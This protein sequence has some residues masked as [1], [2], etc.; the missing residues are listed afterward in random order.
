MIFGSI[1]YLNLL[2]FKIFLKKYIK[3]SSLKLSLNKKK[4]VPSKINSDLEKRRVDAG[5]ISSVKSSKFR[6]NNIGIVAKKEV[7]S[8]FVIDG[9]NKKDKESATSNIL[10]DIL[11]LNGEVIIG[12]K[13]LKYYLEGGK[14]KDLAKEWHK[15]TNLPFVFARFCYNKN[16]KYFNKLSR[17]FEKENI[18]IPQYL[19]KKEAEK[20]GITT[21]QL[22]WYLSFI[23]YKIDK[24]ALRGLNLFL[25]KS[26]LRSK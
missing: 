21:K 16:S 19:L 22:K 23:Y 13:A 4:G 18:K 1:D 7:Y 2:P 12:D 26:K 25:K 14:G 15:K 3:S 6:C 17:E 24:K 20:R 8:V 9:E 10:A 5:F 11:E